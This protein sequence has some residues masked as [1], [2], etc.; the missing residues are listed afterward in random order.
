MRRFRPARPLILAAAVA[1]A[2]S[3]CA[4]SGPPAPVV[5]GSGGPAQS[6]STGSESRGGNDGS[7]GRATQSSRD[8]GSQPA[9]QAERRNAQA[10]P[11]QARVNWARTGRAGIHTVDKG[12]SVYGLAR[13]Y[14]VPIRAI[15]DAN[16]LEP[17]YTLYV[18]QE[19]RIPVP[20]RHVV[21]RGD[22]VYGISRAYGVDMSEL[23]RLNDIQ[24]PYRI[25]PGQV[26]VIPGTG[27]DAAPTRTAAGDDAS[28]SERGTAEPSQ[29]GAPASDGTT[30]QAERAPRRDAQD[31]EQ[32]Q[33]IARLPD[34]PAGTPTPPQPP[35]RKA[36]TAG[37]TQ[38]AARTQTS[39][40]ERQASTQA[41]A[42]PQPKSIPQPPPRAEARFLW[43]VRGKVLSSF[44][45]LD[46]GL[47]NDGI[48]IAAPAGTPVKAAENGVVA[49]VGNELRGFGNLLLIKHA[50][51]W[52]TAYAHTQE[53][54]VGYGEQVRRGQLVARVGATG[55]VSEPQLH[56]EV[57]KG[58]KAK[59]PA[60]LLGSQQAAR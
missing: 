31:A 45:P 58:S 22:T 55:S 20:R 25:T 5:Y 52:V 4:R 41:A 1:L 40:P 15:I 27:R 53:I 30:Q 11:S 50:D 46:G 59:N 60:Q 28:A 21:E 14:Q 43:P 57:R 54:L 10:G 47:H 37:R 7:G 18:G 35:A 24:P 49:Y 39:A 29:Q 48:N 34:A 16:D 9:S 12:D 44:G 33:A 13:R 23:T 19:L 26:L 6:Q 3:A 51:G 8:T 38:T 32:A 17:P 42:A 2:L 56:F 36:D